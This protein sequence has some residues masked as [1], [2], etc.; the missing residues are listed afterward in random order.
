MGKV[1]PGPV[2]KK[3]RPETEVTNDLDSCRTLNLEIGSR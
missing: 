2:F 1:V 3:F